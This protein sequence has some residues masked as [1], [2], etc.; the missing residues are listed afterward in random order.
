LKL[1]PQ[2]DTEAKRVLEELSRSGTGF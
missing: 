1:P 2:E